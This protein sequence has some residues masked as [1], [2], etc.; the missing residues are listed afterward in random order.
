[1]PDM[2]CLL[3]VFVEPVKV[4][5]VSRSVVSDSATPWIVA[6]QASCPFVPK[7][8]LAPQALVRNLVGISTPHGSVPCDYGVSFQKVA[9]QCQLNSWM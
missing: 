2:Q 8:I 9:C 5:N 4:E 7:E 1:M 6:C 3:N